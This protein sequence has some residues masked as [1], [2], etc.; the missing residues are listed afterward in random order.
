MPDTFTYSQASYSPILTHIPPTK[1]ITQPV[2]WAVKRCK[3]K[4]GKHLV[5]AYSNSNRRNFFFLNEKKQPK[6]TKLKIENARFAKLK[7]EN[8]NHVTSVISWTQEDSLESVLQSWYLQKEN[9][10]AMECILR[11]YP[12][13][14]VLGSN[15]LALKVE[16]PLCLYVPLEKNVIWVK[17]IQTRNNKP[18]ENVYICIY[19]VYV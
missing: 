15:I 1:K 4:T 8:D 10:G 14:R 16:N 9:Y 6:F 5:A 19:N 7:L 18:N 17:I 12:Q 11:L 2:V 3:S 13:E